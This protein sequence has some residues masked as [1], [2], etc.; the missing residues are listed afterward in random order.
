MDV[1]DSDDA[2]RRRANRIHKQI[3]KLADGADESSATEQ[4]KRRTPPRVRPNPRKF[5][6]DRMRDLRKTDSDANQDA[7]DDA[8]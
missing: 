6:H 2:R 7:T 4:D 8:S 5:I 3:E 1:P